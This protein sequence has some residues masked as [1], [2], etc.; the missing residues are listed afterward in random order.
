MENS[1][2]CN[3]QGACGCIKV[4]NKESEEK[5]TSERRKLAFYVSF[6]ERVLIKQNKFNSNERFLRGQRHIEEGK[7]EGCMEREEE[8][9][10]I[11]QAQGWRR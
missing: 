11:L 10:L 1:L 5:L 2:R 4:L 7:G 6:V 9:Q 8:I 3:R